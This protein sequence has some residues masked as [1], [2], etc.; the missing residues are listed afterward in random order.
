MRR[1]ISLR[2]KSVVAMAPSAS[3]SLFGRDPPARGRFNKSLPGSRGFRE[4]RGGCP[5]SSADSRKVPF[6]AQDVG[7][8]A[9]LQDRE[10]DDRHAVFL[11][12]RERG[13]IH[14]F[15]ALIERFLVVE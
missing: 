11:G 15:Q 14:D 12:M 8:R 9:L 5:G 1:L 13:C 2:S 6:A 10:L 4:D 3:G 7:N